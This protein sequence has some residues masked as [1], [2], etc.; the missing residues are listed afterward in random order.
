MNHGEFETVIGNLLIKAC[1]NNCGD[2]GIIQKPNDSNTLG[3]YVS[4]KL[5]EI[6]SVL[7]NGTYLFEGERPAKFPNKKKITAVTKEDGNIEIKSESPWAN[8]IV[9]VSKETLQKIYDSYKDN[10]KTAL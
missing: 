8:D 7:K 3:N 9:T 2:V 5:D 4:S 10:T 1:W 6:D